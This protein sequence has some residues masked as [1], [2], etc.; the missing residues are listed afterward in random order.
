MH[1][2]AS[3]RLAGCGR[4]GRGPE[5][6]GDGLTGLLQAGGGCSVLR[7]S[8]IVLEKYMGHTVYAHEEKL[9]LLLA[10]A[11]EWMQQAGA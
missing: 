11:G 1:S 5:E 8:N 2:P 6:G 4:G 3:A 9:V 10:S 7:R